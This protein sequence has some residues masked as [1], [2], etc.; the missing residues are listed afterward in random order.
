MAD[1]RRTI[2]LLLAANAGAIALFGLVRLA[3]P[4]DAQ[5]GRPRSTYTAAAG[6]IPGTETNALYIV[7]EAT[8]ELVVVQWNPNSK[9]LQGLG[10]RSLA[11]DAGAILRPGGG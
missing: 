10:Y 7:D 5:A 6:R 8:Q 4:A 9:Q 11:S 3:S 2:R 1:D